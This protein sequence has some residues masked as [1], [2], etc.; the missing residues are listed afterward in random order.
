MQPV[1]HTTD[2][3]PRSRR[4]GFIKVPNQ[5]NTIVQV[6]DIIIIVIG[7]LISIVIYLDLQCDSNNRPWANGWLFG[8]HDRPFP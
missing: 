5:E 2:G 8:P 3:F 1:Q 7:I 6:L 4:L